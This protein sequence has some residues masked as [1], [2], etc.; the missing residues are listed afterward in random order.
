[1]KRPP[2]E[3]SISNSGDRISAR[4]R[5]LLSPCSGISKGSYVLGPRFG[6][7]RAD[8]PLLTIFFG[9]YGLVARLS[10]AE[11]PVRAAMADGT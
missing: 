6:K 7:R 2:V 5:S 1:M 3:F 10:M 4:I 11:L 8:L 9:I